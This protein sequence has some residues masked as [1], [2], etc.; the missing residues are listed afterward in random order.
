MNTKNSYSKRIILKDLSGGLRTHFDHSAIAKSFSN[1]DASNPDIS[2][3]ITGRV[4]PS[5]KY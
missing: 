3:P 1:T 5:Y 2:L 4:E